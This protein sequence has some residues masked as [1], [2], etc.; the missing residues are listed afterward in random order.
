MTAEHET[1]GGKPTKSHRNLQRVLHSLG[2]SQQ[3]IV[4][5]PVSSSLHGRQQNR[6]F[7][8]GSTISTSPVRLSEKRLAN[9]G[10]KVCKKRSLGSGERAERLRAAVTAP[11]RNAQE[12]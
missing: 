7:P 1:A 9:V 12:G 2:A 8:I 5:S 6:Y 10:F 4:T 11:R 3:G